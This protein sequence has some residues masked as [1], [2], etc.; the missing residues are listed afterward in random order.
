MLVSF[1]GVTEFKFAIVKHISDTYLIQD[2]QE[3]SKM[4]TM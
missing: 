4:T 3:S 2:S 1:Y